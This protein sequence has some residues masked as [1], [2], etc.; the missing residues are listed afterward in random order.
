MDFMN[1]NY[2][3]FINPIRN[4]IQKYENNRVAEEK[5][6]IDKAPAKYRFIKEVNSAIHGGSNTD[7]VFSSDDITFGDI[8][9]IGSSNYLIVSQNC[10]ITIRQN[11]DRSVQSFQLIKVKENRETI[12]AEWLINFFI[13]YCNDF[14]P[15]KIKLNSQGKEFFENTFHNPSADSELRIMGFEAQCL[16]MIEDSL[17]MAN[18]ANHLRSLD[19]KGCDKDL[20]VVWEYV[21]DTKVN[22]IFTV[23]CFWLD[24]LLIRKTNGNVINEETIDKSKEIRLATKRR[25]KKDY[26]DMIG[27]LRLLSKNSLIQAFDNNLLNPLVKVEPLFGEGDVLNGFKL[28]DV[29]RDKKLKNHVARAIHLEMIAK[30]TREAVNESIPI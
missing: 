27:K 5:V 20:S 24:A 25:I 30:Q 12:N 23:P 17:D 19:F 1:V 2:G 28:H 7:P 18:V 8:I 4:S 13:K 16:K 9:T 26:N 3:K 6:E 29:S 22:E 15:E 21:R 11:G 10:D 14:K